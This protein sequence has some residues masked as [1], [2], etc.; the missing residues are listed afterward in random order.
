MPGIGKIC[1]LPSIMH[2][3]SAVSSN[4]SPEA[5]SLFITG[6]K[7]VGETLTGHYTYYDAEGD[8]E[9]ATQYRWWRADDAAGT[10][11]AWI[12][13]ATAQTYT[14]VAADENKYVQFRVI[15]YAATGGSPGT[16]ATSN[17]YGAITVDD[18]VLVTEAAPVTYIDFSSNILSAAAKWAVYFEMA[19]YTEAKSPGQVCGNGKFNTYISLSTSGKFAIESDNSTQSISTIGEVNYKDTDWHKMMVWSDGANVY[20]DVDDGDQTSTVAAGAGNTNMTI[21][22]FMSSYGGT[23][24][25]FD[26]KIN[27]IRVWD[28]TAYAGAWTRVAIQAETPDHEFLLNEGVGNTV[29]D[30]YSAITGTI[31]NPHAAQWERKTSIGWVAKTISMSGY[32]SELRPMQQGVYDHY[33]DK[34]FFCYMQADSD[35]HVA[36]CDHSAGAHT[37]D[38]PKEI[39]AQTTARSY[40]Y[41]S[42]AL[43]HSGKLAVCFAHP[44][45]THV[46]V[47]ISDNA[48]DTS[49]WTVTDLVCA[50]TGYE[51]PRLFVDRR[52]WLYV[53]YISRPASAEAHLRWVHYN[54]SKDEGTTWEGETLLIER[55]VTDPYGMCEIYF[56]VNEIQ[57]Y[58]NGTNERLYMAFTSSGGF[59]YEGTH[60]GGDGLDYL[61]DSTAA[62]TPGGLTYRHLYNV[63]K[64]TEDGIFS[65]TATDV[66]PDA[67]MAFDDGDAYGIAYHNINHSHYYLC[68][69]QFSDHHMYAAD[70]TDLGTKLDRTEMD[71]VPERWYTSPIPPDGKDTGYVPGMAFDSSSN[72]IGF[73]FGLCGVQWDGAAWDMLTSGTYGVVE[74]GTHDG[75]GDSATMTDSTQTWANDEL[76]G[77]WVF[78]TTDGSW[79]KVASNTSDTITFVD[80]MQGG[81]DNDWDV[82]DAF[83]IYD[84]GDVRRIWYADGYYY[85]ALGKLAIYRSADYATW[86]LLDNV[87]ISDTN[88]YSCYCVPVK[89]GH[90]EA[91]LNL[92]ENGMAGTWWGVSCGE[93]QT[94]GALVCRTTD[95]CPATSST[96]TIRVYVCEKNCGARS[97]VRNA[98][99]A[100]TLSI[101]SGGGSI[102]APNPTNAVNGLASFTFNTPVGAGETVIEATAAGLDSYRIHIFTGS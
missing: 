4:S 82:G 69:F 49:S 31:T 36:T 35:P 17:W 58:I 27:N 100:I 41:P 55:D 53:F 51:Y 56:G 28:L 6:D 76:V 93:T 96:T 99:D 16:T 83:V 38:T 14:C 92:H 19:N 101:I 13:G 2:N 32:E 98:T 61:S 66:V 71:A 45:D 23:D 25:Q 87:S 26:G 86:T 62:F 33:S 85:L 60:D 44:H 74:S 88:A 91:L 22:Y 94:A 40:N 59:Q 8:V 89:E 63:T 42:I 65:N 15:P 12:V 46:G 79:G 24:L 81:T 67:P 21:G 39:T 30:T 64:G 50:G 37:W 95:A 11:A 77:D 48:A 34:S 20:F 47:A 18:W 7:I 52:G 84:Y 70:G 43:L 102:D 80:G 10:N 1:I 72:P 73:L 75:A 3:R 97:R 9:G 68:Y 57:P 5:Q 54:Y 78:N 29:N 90:A